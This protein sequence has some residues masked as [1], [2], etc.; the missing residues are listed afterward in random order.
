MN[1][2]NRDSKICPLCNL[3]AKRNWSNLSKYSSEYIKNFDG[4]VCISLSCCNLKFS[5]NENRYLNYESIF[6]PNKIDDYS[7]CYT[8]YYNT[9]S[10]YFDYIYFGK[11]EPFDNK[12]RGFEVTKGGGKIK[13]IKQIQDLYKILTVFQ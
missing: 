1:K 11:G 10:S 4:N 6:L 7:I 9:S 5:F 12:R 13:S 2:T 3:Q 8:Y